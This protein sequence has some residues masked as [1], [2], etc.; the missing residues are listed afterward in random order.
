MV[1]MR[2]VKA[3]GKEDGVLYV[4][5]SEHFFEPSRGAWKLQYRTKDDYSGHNEDPDWGEWRD[6]QIETMPW[7]AVG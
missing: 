4:Q 2:W 1:E 7:A 6:V 5:A 3:T